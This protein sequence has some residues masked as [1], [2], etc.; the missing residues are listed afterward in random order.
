L[1]EKF[2]QEWWYYVGTAYSD[3]GQPFSLQIQITRLSVGGAQVGLGITGIG[4]RDNDA[5]FYLSGLAF[6]FGAAIPPV[7]DHSYSA[8]LVPLVEIT[9]PLGGLQLNLPPVGG[10]QFEFL[11]DAS[12]GRVGEAGS[13]YSIAAQGRGYLASA[14]SKDTAEAEYSVSFIIADQRGSVMEGVGGYVGPEMFPGNPGGAPASYECAQPHLAI[15]SGTI[16]I[17]GRTV[18]IARGNLWLDRQMV[19]RPPI[20]QPRRATP[21]A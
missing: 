10:W 1:R 15:Q 13:A 19:A 7:T 21:R 5:S 14:N 8:T 9:A 2:G 6:G 17:D 3:A 4:W 12:D 11:P 18:N 20:P 16:V